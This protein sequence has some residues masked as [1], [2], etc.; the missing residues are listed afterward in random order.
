MR[1]DG[2]VVC[3][4]SD[5]LGRADSAEGTFTAVSAGGGFSC[6]LRGDGAVVC[7]GERDVVVRSVGPDGSAP[8]VE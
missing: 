1:G 3:W 4:G 5:T 7:W 8:G 2:K 6:G